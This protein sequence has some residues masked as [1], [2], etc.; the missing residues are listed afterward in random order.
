M[1]AVVALLLAADAHA[2]GLRVLLLLGGGMDRELAARVEGQCAD[3][4]LAALRVERALPADLP[5]QIAFARAAGARADLVIWF[6]AD[7][8]GPVAY[9][10]SGDRIVARRVGQATGP[11]SRSASIEALAVAVRTVVEGIAASRAEPVEAARATRA[12]AWGEAGWT[13]LLDGTAPSGR[14]GVMLR[15]GA[16]R[17]PWSLAAMAG[18]SPAASV[19]AAPAT[20]EIS[21]QQAGLVAGLELLPARGGWSAALELGVGAARYRR[22]TT[23][24]GDGLVATPAAVSWSALVAPGVRVAR[25]T[26]P[27]AWLALG[28]GADVLATPP[29]FRA[30]R[31]SGVDAVASTWACAPRLTLSL[32]LDGR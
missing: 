21:R 25:R 23:T 6:G 24:A 12:R 26:F 13:A 17:G 14:R 1:A 11:L 18:I 9:V 22:A 4:D 27:G 7:A 19:E 8:G 10:S 5:G 3:L 16:A 31:A 28:L 15:A 2:A 20:I 32:L 30:R 29:S